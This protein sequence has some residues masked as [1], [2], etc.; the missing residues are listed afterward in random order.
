[1]EFFA[2]WSLGGVVFFC[3]AMGLMAGWISMLVFICLTG[4]MRTRDE[5][6][7]YLEEQRA[8]RAAQ[9]ASQAHRTVD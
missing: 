9:K 5:Q 7:Q 4:N 3:F 1:M 2:G 6:A 8:I